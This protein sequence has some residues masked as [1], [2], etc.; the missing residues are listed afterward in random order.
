[1]DGYSKGQKAL[2]LH[3]H[4]VRQAMMRAKGQ[5]T[6]LQSPGNLTLLKAINWVGGAQVLTPL[7]APNG[8]TEHRKNR[9]EW[10]F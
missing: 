2:P 6:Y 4:L 3:P 5:H 8:E 7:T 10:R 1:M 9:H